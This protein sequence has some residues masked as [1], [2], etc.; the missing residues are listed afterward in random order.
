MSAEEVKKVMAV[1]WEE[2]EPYCMPHG[3]QYKLENVDNYLKEMDELLLEAGMEGLGY[4]SQAENIQKTAL[5]MGLLNAYISTL[6]SEIDAQ[7]DQPLYRGFQNE[8]TEQLSRIRMEDYSTEN[9]LGL[10]RHYKIHDAYGQIMEYDAQAVSLTM[11]DFLGLTSLNDNAGHGDLIGMPKEFSDFTNLFAVEYDKIKDNLKDETGKEVTL[12]EYLTYLNTKGEF[13]NKMDKPLQELISAI[14]DVTIIKPLIEMCTGYDMITGEDLTDFE[15]GLKGVFAVVDVVTLF[16]GIKAS[17]VAKLFSREA[18][19]TGG[20]IIATDLISNGTAYAVGK[21]GEELG[22]PL[23][24]TLMLSLGA[25]VTVSLTA[26]KYVFKDSAGNVVLEAGADE[27]DGI[28]T[29]IKQ[30]VETGTGVL[31]NANYAQKTYSNTFSAEGRKIYSDLAG[32]PINTIDD[33]VNAINS[34]KV[35]VAD[36]PVEYIVR[37]GNTLIL[38]TRTSQAL[39]QAGIPRSQWNAIDRTGDTLFEELLTGQLSRN[40]LTSEGISTVRPSGGQ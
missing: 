12:E 35:N 4:Q 36:L 22:L 28:R 13:D 19:E 14:L 30:G 29:Q 17:G 20:R 33:L 32:E 3:Y 38:N 40:K 34:G 24:I 2:K 21:M 9:T 10:K 39:T 31:D 27:V 6:M 1:Q 5:G 16:V 37:D 15:R 7:I 8:A 26:G 11:K 25:G 18:L 23:P